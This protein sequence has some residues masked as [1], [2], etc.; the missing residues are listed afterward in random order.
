MQQGMREHSDELIEAAK[1]AYL[2]SNM[3]MAELAR[4]SA[5]LIGQH[6]TLNKLLYYSRRD[7]EGRWDVLRK[8]RPD[9]ISLEINH[10][11]ALLYEQIVANAEGGYFVTGDNLDETILIETL[12]RIDGIQIRKINPGSTE[13]ALVNAYMNILSKANIQADT[14]ISAKTSREQVLDAIEEY[15]EESE[16]G[17][18]PIPAAGT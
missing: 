8:A 18:S 11:R 1:A 13:P 5:S 3:S 16:N 6:V 14:G 4:N 15:L 10:L 9:K 12:S 17:H 2:K 7:P